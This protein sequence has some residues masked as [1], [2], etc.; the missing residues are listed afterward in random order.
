M[1]S[2]KQIIDSISVSKLRDEVNQFYPLKS[3]GF[4]TN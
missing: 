2:Y 1:I 3:N 4:T